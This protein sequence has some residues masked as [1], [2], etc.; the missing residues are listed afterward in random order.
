[1]SSVPQQSAVAL[2]PCLEALAAVEQDPV[3][4]FR[5]QPAALELVAALLEAA[6][7]EAEMLVPRSLAYLVSL[8]AQGHRLASPQLLAPAIEVFELLAGLA[9]QAP[10]HL[11]Q[12]GEFLRRYI[13]HEPYRR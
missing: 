11:H 1:M 13:E 8:A 5:L 9:A 6:V 2:S 12:F 3:Q 10:P 4:V 7:S